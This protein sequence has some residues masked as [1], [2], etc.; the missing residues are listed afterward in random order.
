MKKCCRYTV[1]AGLTLFIS[2]LIGFVMLVVVFM[3]PTEKIFWHI[4][5]SASSILVEPEYFQIMP[6]VGGAQFDNFTEAIYLNVALADAEG[7]PVRAALESSTYSS[8]LAESPQENL[9]F[10]LNFDDSVELHGSQYRF[11]NGYLIFIKPLLSFCSYPEIRNL[12]YILQSLLMFV[13]LALMQRKGYGKYSLALLL[14]YI[15]LNPICMSM[16][17]TFAGFFYCTVIPCILMMLFNDKLIQK[18]LY[19]MFFLL[20]GICVIYFNMNYFQIISFGIPIAF[21]FILNSWPKNLKEFLSSGVLLF[22]AW[23]LGYFGM[24]VMKWIYY[25][26][27]VSPEIFTEM[28]DTILFRTSSVVGGEEVSRIKAIGW[29]F[30]VVVKNE[31]WLFFEI[32]FAFGCIFVALK[33]KASFITY[34]KQLLATAVIAT[35]PIIRYSIFANH[36]YI[37]YWVTYRCLAMSVFVINVFLTD[38]ASRKAVV[39]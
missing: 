10:A 9:S 31:W 20:I 27:L 5:A 2:S 33:N 39:K 12:N 34:R 16:N 28:F 11:W 23:F 36:V 35:I 30:Y 1:Q 37:H 38:I 26:I 29:N 6:E 15:F 19:F 13:L 18:D 24:M 17:M 7:N 25:A 22:A 14:S 4:K 3:I 32:A 8:P 21:Y